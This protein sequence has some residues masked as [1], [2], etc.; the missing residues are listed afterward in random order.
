MK[1]SLDYWNN[2]TI[3]QKE[4]HIRQKEKDLGL[5]EGS[6]SLAQPFFERLS[7]EELKGLEEIDKHPYSIFPKCSKPAYVLP[8]DKKKDPDTDA[9]VE[10]RNEHGLE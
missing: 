5:E 3:E 8:D 2:L 9:E 1:K 4:K 10:K 7:D 6:I